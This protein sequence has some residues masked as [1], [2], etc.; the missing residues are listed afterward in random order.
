VAS[1]GSELSCDGNDRGRQGCLL[2]HFAG[3]DLSREILLYNRSHDP[4][5]SL[6]NYQSFQDALEARLMSNPAGQG[7]ALIWIDLTGLRREFSIRGWNG[8]EALARRIANTLRSVV[9]DDALL[10][11]TGDSSFLVAMEGSKTDKASRLSIQAIMDALTPPQNGSGTRI[12]VAAG[13]AFFP[14]DTNSVED[15]VRFSI[16]AADQASSVKSRSVVAFHSRMNSVVVRDH[17]LEL[18]MSKG[19]EQGQFRMVYQPKVNLTTGQVVAAEA[20]MRW[21][22]PHLGTIP[23]TEF[24]PVA[25]RS[26]LIHRIFEFSLRAALKHAQHLRDLGLSLPIIAVN[27]SVANV[28]DDNFARTV[29]RIMEEIP[30]APTQLEL[31]ITESLAF[32]NEDLFRARVR[33]LKAIGVRVSIDDFGTRYTGFNVLKKLHLNTIKIDQCFIR[34]IDLSQNMLS[35]CQTIVAMGRQLKMRTVAEGIE[36]PGEL[37]AMRQVGCEAGQGF[38]FQRAVGADEFTAFLRDWPERKLTLGFE[39]DRTMFDADALYAV[40]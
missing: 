1:Q 22:H 4:Q 18:E 23:P 19:L 6:L 16:L 17:L 7:I 2:D 40:G 28:R 9:A 8:A 38:L 29:R 32:D 31:E 27:A 11:R 10:G 30:I 26:Y 36:E 14:S 25:E 33:Q 24:I 5:T 20:L 35:L 34:G 13:V 37:E 39:D 3:D 12:E 15:L 21:T